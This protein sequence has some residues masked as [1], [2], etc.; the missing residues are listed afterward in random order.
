MSFLVALVCVREA[1]LLVFLFSGK[2]MFWP[3][4][5]VVGILANRRLDSCNLQAISGFGWQ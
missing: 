1:S 5:E 4:H 2:I 3:H